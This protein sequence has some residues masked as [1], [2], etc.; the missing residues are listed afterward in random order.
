[1]DFRAGTDEQRNMFLGIGEP[2][3]YLLIDVLAVRS[4]E[5]EHNNMHMFSRLIHNEHS[6]L[7]PTWQ[8][9]RNN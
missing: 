6:A 2:T 7:E 9:V 5:T 8:Q 4:H 1:M 3:A